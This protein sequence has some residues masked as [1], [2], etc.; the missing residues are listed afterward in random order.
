MTSL[1]LLSTLV[2]IVAAAV[3]S[4]VLIWAIRPILTRYALTPPNARSSHKVPTAQGA[5]IAVIFATLATAAAAAALMSPAA[6]G[7]IGMLSG[8]AVLLAIAGAIDD[9]RP[10]PVGPRL[11]LQAVAVG[12][13]ILTT[14]GELRVVPELPGWVEQTCLLFAGIWFVNLVN[15]MDGLDWMTVAEVV[16]V[17]GAVMLLGL[18]EQQTVAATMIAAAL[19]GAI[20]GFAPFN[21]PVAKVF[22]GDVGS[23]PIGL[24]LGWCLL[25]LA[26]HQHLTAAVLLPLYYLVDTA[27]TLFR[28]LA[29]GE[30]I[31]LAHRQHYYQKATDNGWTVLAV[32]THV[33]SV[34]IFLAILAWLSVKLQSGLADAGLLV[35]GVVAIAVM[36]A[37]F[38]TR[39]A[40]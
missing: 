22:L 12:A 13:V 27:L 5:G 38:S 18:L 11:A 10:M 40:E 7:V 28:R 19:G 26:Y 30:A 9:Q 29:G 24:L 32:V 15:F 17:T 1:D 3:L 16:P 20:I 35:L 37:R 31:L 25:Q 4:A 23:L 2:T 39:R 6:L 36:L 8:A 34:N 21:R 33:F 14:P